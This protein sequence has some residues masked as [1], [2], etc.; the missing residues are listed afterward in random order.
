[1]AAEEEEEAEGG[2]LRF[3]EV[4]VMRRPAHALGLQLGALRSS[5]RLS[6][7]EVSAAACGDTAQMPVTPVHRVYSSP[8][9]AGSSPHCGAT[10]WPL[11]GK[12]VWQENDSS[13]R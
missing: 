9:C 8:L 4:R 7:E 6:D 11:L 5:P 10:S 13:A 2:E 3:A 12:A 1:M